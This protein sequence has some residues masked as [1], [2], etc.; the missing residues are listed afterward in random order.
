MIAVE[1]MAD[2]EE[3]QP[4][5]LDVQLLANEELVKECTDYKN[6]AE[7][8]DE[9]YDLLNQLED[10]VDVGSKE[11]TV[12]RK[13]KALKTVH[14]SKYLVPVSINAKSKESYSIRFL[15]AG[16]ISSSNTM[17]LMVLDPHILLLFMLAASM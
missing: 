17:F 16:N 4:A 3:G 15:Y 9:H 1:T 6:E 11:K 5:G 10:T 2:M 8:D 7:Q 14:S 13:R 12:C